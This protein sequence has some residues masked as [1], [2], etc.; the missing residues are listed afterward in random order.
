MFFPPVPRPFV[1]DCKTTTIGAGPIKESLVQ[2]RSKAPSW[3]KETL[4]EA[5]NSIVTQK[6]RFTQASS[7]Y[8]IPKGTLYDNIL[9]KSKRMLVLDELGLDAQ[10]EEA[11]LDFCCETSVM[12]YNRRTNKSLESIVAFVEKLKQSKGQPSFKLGNLMGFRWWWAFCKKHNI[13]SLFYVKNN[14]NNK[15]SKNKNNNNNNNNHHSN[16]NNNNRSSPSSASSASSASS[17]NNNLSPS[18]ADELMPEN[19]SKPFEEEGGVLP[20]NGA[21]AAVAAA[22]SAFRSINNNSIHLSQAFQL[23]HA[24]LLQNHR[25]NLRSRT[26]SVD[27]DH[28]DDSDAEPE[29]LSVHRA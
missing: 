21:M 5:I 6:M 20:V 2:W 4:Q 3:S 8:N 15:S 24:F 14:N 12:P 1:F 25:H 16:N 28:G 23:S 18:P 9:G 27:H 22:A 26:H 19:L 11:V 29:N 13:V 7:H 17:N 10:D